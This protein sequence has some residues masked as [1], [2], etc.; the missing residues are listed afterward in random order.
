MHRYFFVCF[1]YQINLLV[2]ICTHTQTVDFILRSP[3]LQ[4]SCFSLH[5]L[6]GEFGEACNYLT[7]EYN[8]QHAVLDQN[9]YYA[10]K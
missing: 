8:P 5:L 7:G 3:T 10:R 1:V 6:F 9:S 4:N 2:A